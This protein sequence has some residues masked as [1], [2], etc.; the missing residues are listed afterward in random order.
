MK[1][2][3]VD[4]RFLTDALIALAVCGAISALMIWYSLYFKQHYQKSYEYHHSEFRENSQRY[5]SVDDDERIIRENYGNFIELYNKGVLGRENRLNWLETL[6]AAGDSIKMP[7]LRFQVSSQEAIK[8]PYLNDVSTGS[9]Q[10]FSSRMHLDMGLLHEYDFSALLNDLDKQAAG[11]YSVSSCSFARKGGEFVLD[12]KV[13]NIAAS[14]DLD[15]YT[16]NLPGEGL[17]L[18]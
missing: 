3:D 11:M 15:W 14:C 10:V 4:W 12:P 7:G 2:L 6:R 9:F 8:P 16:V 13:A 1:K 18:K 17:V 5:L